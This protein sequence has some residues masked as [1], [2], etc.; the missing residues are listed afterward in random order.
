MMAGLGK[1]RAQTEMCYGLLTVQPWTPTLIPASRDLDVNFSGLHAQ[2]SCKLLKQGMATIGGMS[3]NGS[4]A[5]DVDG[6]DDFSLLQPL[7]LITKD[8][9]ELRQI[10]KE[11]KE[12]LQKERHNDKEKD[13]E[14]SQERERERGYEKDRETHERE[15]EKEKGKDKMEKD[16]EPEKDKQ[17]EELADKELT[18]IHE[19]KVKV[20]SEENGLPGGG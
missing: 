1:M 2:Q 12:S 5:N 8:V 15:K 9:H 16:K 6:D 19:E 11:K 18:R 14:L 17:Q 10:I 20:K 13:K 4:K 7:D 3:P